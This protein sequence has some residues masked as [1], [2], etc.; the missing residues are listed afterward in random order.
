MVQVIDTGGSVAGRIGKG[1]GKGLSEQIPKEVERHRLSSGLESLSNTKETNPLKQLAS[2]YAIPGVRENPEIANQAFNYLRQQVAI[3]EAKGQQPEQ[4]PGV[5]GPQQDEVKSNLPASSQPKSVPRLQSTPEAIRQ[6]GL[7]YIARFPTRYRSLEEGEAQYQKDVA[8][9]Q[10]QIAFVNDRFKNVGATLLQQMGEDKFNNVMGELQREFEKRA[11][12]A[13][14]SGKMSET[15][16]ADKYSKQMLDFAKARDA[17]QTMG[18]DR[19]RALFGGQPQKAI[20]AAQKAYEEA[21]MPEAFR[22]DLISYQ[23]LSYHRA[24]EVAFPLDKSEEEYFK[25][26]PVSKGVFDKNEEV[27]EKTF[28]RLKDTDSLQN[29][30]LQLSKKGYSPQDFLTYA[31]DHEKN[32]T[33]IQVREL[34]HIG[35]FQPSLSDILYYT[36]IGKGG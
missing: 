14:L 17:Q 32:L 23:K 16:A 7:S 1:F 20:K 31:L 29:F 3:N 35:S 28:D 13:V 33:P 15:E 11:E 27:F 5:A 36:L 6:G 12:D 8:N 25:K 19:W 22:N 2:L 18:P 26:L 34:Q 9:Q 24:S 30:A 4:V 21:D 10:G